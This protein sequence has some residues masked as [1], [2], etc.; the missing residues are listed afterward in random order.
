M[1]FRAGVDDTNE[2]SCRGR[3]LEGDTA[4]R[5]SAALRACI[6]TGVKQ[7][8]NQAYHLDAC[9]KP[10]SAQS[11]I[12]LRRLSTISPSTI[13]TV[14]A[15]VNSRLSSLQDVARRKLVVEVVQIKPKLSLTLAVKS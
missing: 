7:G 15:M 4:A 5:S 14:V 2:R 8:I 12:A 11:L 10:W 13:T 9:C 3:R 1:P 6:R